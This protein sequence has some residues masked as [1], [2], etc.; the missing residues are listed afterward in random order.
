MTAALYSFVAGFCYGCATMIAMV[1]VACIY[2]GY[3]EARGK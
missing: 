3:V 2:V 1:V